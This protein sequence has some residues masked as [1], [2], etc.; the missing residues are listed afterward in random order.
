MRGYLD[1]NG[2]APAFSRG[3]YEIGGYMNVAKNAFNNISNNG[4]ALGASAKQELSYRT[5]YMRV[6]KDFLYKTEKLWRTEV[7]QVMCFY[8]IAYAAMPTRELDEGFT[9]GG[10]LVSA[11]KH[12]YVD[13]N[14]NTK[15]FTEREFE[16]KQACNTNL[17]LATVI[18]GGHRYKILVPYQGMHTEMHPGQG[19]QS[20]TDLNF[21]QQWE[22]HAE[23]MGIG[24]QAPNYRKNGGKSYYYREAGSD[25]PYVQSYVDVLY[26]N[27]VPP[28]KK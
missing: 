14:G 18:E 5:T 24:S 26:N 13:G 3:A 7:D 21:V 6:T 4:S 20:N 22:Y 17:R 1:E 25:L 16:I 10:V 19:H 15:Y 28:T 23:R 12:S 11:G 8:P 9:S 27:Q 2:N